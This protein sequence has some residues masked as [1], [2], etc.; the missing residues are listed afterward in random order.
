MA[1]RIVRPASRHEPVWWADDARY[2]TGIPGLIGGAVLGGI[3][4][5]AVALGA[6]LWLV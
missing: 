2:E 3:L 4:G 1:K 5:T 6:L